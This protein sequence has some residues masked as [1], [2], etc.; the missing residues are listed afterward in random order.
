M[1]PTVRPPLILH[2]K[3]YLSLT[4]IRMLEGGEA[5]T[6]LTALNVLDYLALNCEA[7]LLAP[8]DPLH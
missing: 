3:L 2:L 8:R 5:G 1:V 6:R 7:V 4:L